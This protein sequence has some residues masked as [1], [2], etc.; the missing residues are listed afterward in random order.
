MIGSGGDAAR[1]ATVARPAAGDRR[2]GRARSCAPGSAAPDRRKV[3]QTLLRALRASGLGAVLLYVVQSDLLGVRVQAAARTQLAEA[4]DGR[5]RRCGRRSGWRRPGRSCSSSCRTREMARAPRLELGR[6]PRR[7]A[8]GL[9]AGRRAGR[10]VLVRLR[11]VRARQ[12]GRPRL[13]PHLAPGRGDAPDRAQPGSADRGRRRSSRRP[14]RCATRSTTTS[15]D[16]AKESSQLKITHYDFDID[17]VKAKE[18]GVTTNGILVFVRGAKNEQLG[19][20]KEIE[21]AKTAL[22]TLDKEV[23][24]RLLLDRQAAAHGGLHARPRRAHLGARRDRHRQARRH[25][26]AARRPHRSDL[27]RP[28]RSTRRTAS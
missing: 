23:Q 24:Q 1:V 8:V 20:P 16:L 5:W 12:E 2:D 27:R 26:A 19:L 22:K 17:P 21:G 25:R 13:L 11:R 6:D 28:L 10:R 3:E 7:D 9:R 18:Y 14:T 15:S 4:V